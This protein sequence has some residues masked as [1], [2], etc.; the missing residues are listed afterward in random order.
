MKNNL[1]GLLIAF[2]VAAAAAGPHSAQPADEKPA[3]KAGAKADEKPK[4]TV[5]IASWDETLKMVAGHKGKIVVLDAW[6]TSCTPCVKEF[7]NLVKLHER[8]AKD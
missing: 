8:R 1:P 6:S 4:V 3:A 2:V 5:K 7:P